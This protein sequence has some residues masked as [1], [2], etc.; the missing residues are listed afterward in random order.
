MNIR[1]FE[2]SMRGRLTLALI[3]S[4]SLAAPYL[5]HLAGLKGDVFLPIFLG[6][7]LASQYL[8]SV[9]VVGV[10][11]L[12]PLA[13]HI[14]TGMPSRAPLPILQVLT[15]E[16]VILGM[17]AIYLRRKA[18]KPLLRVGIPIL[19]GRI[20]SVIL[21]FLYPTLYLELWAANLILGVPGMLLNT[22]FALMVL[23]LLPV[24]E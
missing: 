7:V 22:A 6:V 14:L 24:E 5:F 23:R 1:S 10:A 17:A 19:L 21:V 8:K 12:A 4:L 13:N 9:E 18:F 20:S 11:L 2:I 3:I 15:L 16:A